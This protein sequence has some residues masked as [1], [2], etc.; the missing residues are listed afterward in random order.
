VHGT[1]VCQAGQDDIHM[2]LKV[3]HCDNRHVAMN[4]F[5]PVLM[6]GL[7]FSGDEDSNHGLLGCDAM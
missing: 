6:W 3:Q 5:F 2:N 7:G 4:K 1:G